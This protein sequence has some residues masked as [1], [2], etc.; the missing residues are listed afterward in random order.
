MPGKTDFAW[1][2]G[3][4]DCDGHIG[5]HRH[6]PNPHRGE[7]RHRYLVVVTLSSVSEGIP[8]QLHR[9][10]GGSLSKGATT[11]GTPFWAW[12]VKNRMA[13]NVLR[14]VQPYLVGKVEAAELC[15]SLRN[16]MVQTKGISPSDEEWGIREQLY[17]KSRSLAS[18]GGGH[19]R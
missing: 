11:H 17:Q 10:F 19:A 8:T 6:K 7:K 18:K 15:L 2:A 9:M 3:A 16:R 4:L 12:Q 1:A 14:S 5:I 13:E